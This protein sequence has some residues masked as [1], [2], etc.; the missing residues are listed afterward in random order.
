MSHA[1]TTQP[2]TQPEAPTPCCGGATRWLSVTDAAAHASRLAAIADPTRLQ[3]MSIIANSPD[4]E[5][6]ACDFVEPLGKS[7]PTISHHLKVLAEAGIVEGDKRGRWVWYRLASGEVER[8][9]ATLTGVA[10]GEV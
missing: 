9:A 3:V 8:L 2:E 5:V 7:Q 4:G 10:G 1:D 6:C